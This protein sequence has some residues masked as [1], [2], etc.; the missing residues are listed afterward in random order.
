MEWEHK[1]G[2]LH[3]FSR[4]YPLT[5]KST[6]GSFMTKEYDYNFPY[7]RLLRGNKC[8]LSFSN[9][10][11][12]LFLSFNHWSMGGF[13]MTKENDYN[14]PYPRLLRVNP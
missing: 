9:K 7:P 4:L 12:R 5:L 8:I 10:K 14:F 11:S 2:T 3:P 1:M 13:F 6:G